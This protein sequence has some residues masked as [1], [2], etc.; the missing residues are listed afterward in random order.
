M[1]RL[2]RLVIGNRWRILVGIVSLTVLGFALS[3]VVSG[4][5][6]N[7]NSDYSDPSSASAQARAELLRATG[8][9]PDEGYELLVTLPAA[10]SIA[11][12]APAV[13]TDAVRL[14][15]SRP[16]VVAVSDAWS[17][18]TPALISDS[19]RTALVTAT[20][21]T[22][23]EDTATHA[24][25]ASIDSDPT[26]DGRVLLGGPT[27]LNAQASD[28]SLKDLSFAETV[29]LPILLVLLLVVFGSVVSAL[30]PLLG[31][32][33]SIALTTLLLLVAASLTPVSVYSLNLVYALGIG[34]S[35]DFN[36]LIVS[37]FREEM[38]HLGVAPAALERTLAT[39]GRT[40]LFSAATVTAALG[41]L[42]LF[43]I[44]AFS[45]MGLAGMMV[46][47]CSTLNAVV[48]LPAVL[49][50][51]G[52]RVDMFP[53]LRRRASSPSG[54]DR[55]FWS[56]LASWVMRWRMA[57]APLA[58]A[59]LLAIGIPALA[60]HFTG[61]STQ[62]LPA[63][64]QATQVDRAITATY[65]GISAAPLELVVSGGA[66]V[67]AQVQA[68]D[69]AVSRI[70]GVRSV[71]PPD[72]ISSSLWEVDATLESQ[73]ISTPA[74]STLDRV[75]AIPTSLEVRAFGFTADFADE[76]STLAAHLPDAAVLLAI[77]TLV[78]L[79][80]MTGSVVLPVKAL[81]MNTLTLGATLGLLV[82]V[83][84]HGFLSGVLGFT[85]D[86]GVNIETPVLVGALAFGL[87]T[88]YGV[89]LL[90]RIREGYLSGLRTRDAVALGLQRVGRVVTSAAVLF[91]IAVGALVLSS[92][93]VLKEIG[94][95]AALAVLIDVSVVR[96]LLV[97]SLM[98]IL[99]RWNW[100]APS[101]L[102]GFHRRLGLDRIEEAQPE[103]ATA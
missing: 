66:A 91:C 53:V 59:A 29:A 4:K 42:L 82:L 96:A 69:A 98:A 62:E 70:T 18:G 24:L 75:R 48:L 67:T 89:F 32:L 12:P 37:R 28:Q 16:E 33:V 97:P 57:V 50:L 36:L 27:A 21:R 83:F 15:R 43:P 90:G 51:L 22:V 8:A 30:L 77:T 39:A 93:L 68:Y 25:Q 76:E 72:R 71:A 9:D 6:T 101:W 31:A 81:L 46:T 63:S 94:L 49:A 99:G 2:A 1:T 54:A 78:I 14:L 11:D 55:G 58:A 92:T 84:Q 61:Y 65:H 23:D 88:D 38:A 95:G 19:G 102:A 5:L 73:A 20:V 100:W 44:P 64:L 26:L 87:S 40:V 74:L 13:V 45:S 56:L 79:F 103:G 34:L 10:A 85:S 41:A 80:L 47:L 35:I 3:G 86:G 52:R 7:G 60:V 17:L